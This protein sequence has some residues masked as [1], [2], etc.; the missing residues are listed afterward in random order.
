MVRKQQDLTLLSY[1]KHCHPY[2]KDI[3]DDFVA[4]TKTQVVEYIPR[5]ITVNQSE[6]QGKTTIESST[7]Y[8]RT[9]IYKKLAEKIAAHEAYT[10]PSTLSVN[11][12]R[13]WA[14]KCAD[15][16]LAHEQG[17]VEGIKSGI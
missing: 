10:V 3:I 15:H 12:L 16:L 5:S 17:V 14:E 6:L 8:Y 4:Q 11:E 2:S 13:E 7:N 9:Q 1:Q